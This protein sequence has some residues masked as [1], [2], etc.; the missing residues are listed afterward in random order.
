MATHVELYEAL[1]PHVGPEAAQMIAEAV[2][3]AGNLATKDD[4][5]AVKADIQSVRVEVQSV[6]TEIQSVRTEIQSVRTEI[7][8]VKA[9]VFRWGLTFFVPM[10]L[11]VIAIVIDLLRT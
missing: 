1:K 9:D 10:W 7:Q 5:Y 6:R 8:S 2:P 11:A 3:P 4:I